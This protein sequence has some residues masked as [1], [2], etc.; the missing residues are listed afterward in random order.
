MADIGGI[1]R[2]TTS[3]GENPGARW[4][5]FV[6][7]ARLLAFVIPSTEPR[8][9][10]AFRYLLKTVLTWNPGFA[11]KERLVIFN[12]FTG[13]DFRSGFAGE[14][15]GQYP[16]EKTAVLNAATGEGLGALVS[17]LA[18]DGNHVVA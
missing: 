12:R 11:E 9:A 15:A 10:Q 5:T 8:P 18:K 2:G 13:G 17:L 4:L 6:E 16:N 1:S 14:H 7:T 3:V